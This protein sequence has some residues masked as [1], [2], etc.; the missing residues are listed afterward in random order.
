MAGLKFIHAAMNSWKSASIIQ[1]LYNHQ[2]NWKRSILIKPW[3][4]TKAGWMISSR[5]GLQRQVEA[6]IAPKD[7]IRLTI[8]DLL[9]WTF[10]IFA[11]EA[12]F[13]SPEQVEELSYIATIDDIPVTCYWLRTD[14]FD[15]PF[16][17]SAK[18]LAIAD[19]IVE[20][21][22]ENIC[23]CWKKATCNMRLVNWVPVFS[24]EQVSIDWS[25]DD[26]AYQAVCRKCYLT[27]RGY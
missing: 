25:D 9:D 13:F 18:L 11:D 3:I 14:A 2:S 5:V 21:S 22:T 24:G 20:M 16:P 15:N 19:E 6:V 17:W 10:A 23:T 12:Q 26:I 1:S 27:K 4:D 7:S 8:K